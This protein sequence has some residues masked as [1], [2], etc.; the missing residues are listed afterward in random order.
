MQSLHP[1]PPPKSGDQILEERRTT[2]ELESILSR[3]ATNKAL[4]VLSIL[5]PHF[6][7]ALLGGNV[8]MQ[9]AYKELRKQ[10]LI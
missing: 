1:L 3:N 6:R 9:E 7:N 10:K 8:H 2:A 5:L 4:A